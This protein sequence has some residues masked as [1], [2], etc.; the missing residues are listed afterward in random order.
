MVFVSSNIDVSD[1]LRNGVFGTVSATISSSHVN[2]SGESVEEVH[3]VLVRFDSDQV[4]REARAKSLYKRIEACAVPISK[5]EISFKTNT[6]HERKTISVIRKQ[7]PLICHGQLLYT[8]F[9]E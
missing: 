6:C 2:G 3:V 1:G 8:M 4:G 7:F 9:R 5:T